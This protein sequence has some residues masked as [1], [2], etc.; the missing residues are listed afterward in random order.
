MSAARSS[1]RFAAADFFVPSMAEDVPQAAQHASAFA[2]R[3]DPGVPSL[4]FV[5]GAWSGRVAMRLLAHGL[6]LDSLEVAMRYNTTC[7]VDK[8]ARWYAQDLSKR[9]G[10]QPPMDFNF[11]LHDELPKFR[12]AD[13]DDIRAQPGATMPGSCLRQLASDT[14]GIVE[15]SPML[16]RG[17]LPGEKGEGVMIV[18]D[19]GPAANARLIARYPQRLPAV[20]YRTTKEG[21]PKLVPYATGMAALWPEG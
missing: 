17:D 14:L 18:R 7:D 10:N 6:R 16:W 8:F 21:P 1:D 13:S 12:I 19:M 4:V 11:N 15:I 3:P 20:L 2:S 9:T 5:H